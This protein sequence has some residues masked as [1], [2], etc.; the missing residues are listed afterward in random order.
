[1]SLLFLAGSA[2]AATDN[3]TANVTVTISSVTWINV[4]PNALAW[5]VNPGSSCGW[6]GPGTSSTSCNES[7]DNY[8]AVQVENIGSKNITKVWFNSTYP[9]SN[10]F[11]QGA[12][13]DNSA[14]F[15]ALAN[16]SATTVAEYY[17]INRAEYNET[18]QLVYIT[19][20][21]GNI[22]PHAN[23][24][25]GRFRNASEEYFWIINKT[26]N[27]NATGATLYVGAIAHTRTVTGKVDFSAAGDRTSVTLTG[28]GQW[29]VGDIDAGPL[30]GYCVQVNATCNQVFL[31]KY[32]MDNPGAGTTCDNARY[33]WNQAG[34]TTYNT[35]WLVPG[36]S[37][38][39][40][41]KVFVPYGVF[42]G[43]T[44]QG[45]IAVIA[46]DA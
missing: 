22:P 2:S 34:T 5:T 27:C 43:A 42:E 7:T 35:G 45:T 33:V 36:N 37:A 1:M 21:E 39:M 11:A 17:F 26:G 18:R 23:M 10:P 19:D 13:A 38:V 41:I 46:S 24:V 3:D 12:V 29:G 14:N 31:Y 44:T 30:T 15:V 4:D 9:T 6:G 40:K 20:P 28:S 32:N 8:Y 25:Y 16:E